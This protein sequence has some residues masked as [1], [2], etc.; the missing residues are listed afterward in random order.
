MHGNSRKWS[1]LDR[2]SAFPQAHPTLFEQGAPTKTIP[3][4]MMFD[5]DLSTQDFTAIDAALA[6]K[7]VLDVL[8]LP[9]HI[10]MTVRRSASRSRT[11]LR[12]RSRL[13]QKGSGHCHLS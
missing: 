13:R 6:L 3:H 2:R 10:K 12:L 9:A 8:E 1:A 5:L 11:K 4:Q 7:D